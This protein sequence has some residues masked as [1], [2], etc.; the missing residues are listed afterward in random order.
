MLEV[1]RF[2]VTSTLGGVEG[3]ADCEG[4]SKAGKGAAGVFERVSLFKSLR[5]AEDD[6]AVIMRNVV[7]F[8]LGFKVGLFNPYALRAMCL[9]SAR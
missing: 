8:A 3:L 1:P 7:C 6:G 2:R 4:P 5:A 9:G